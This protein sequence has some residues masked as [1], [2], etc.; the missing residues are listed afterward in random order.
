MRGPC[1][2]EDFRGNPMVTSKMHTH[3][4]SCERVCVEIKRVEFSEKVCQS[5]I[6]DIR[7][8]RRKKGCLSGN[9]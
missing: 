6:S 4:K 2:D 1:S 9:K 8:I 5:E 7:Y 3:T